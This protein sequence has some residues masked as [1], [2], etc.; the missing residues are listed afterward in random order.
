M[1]LERENVPPFQTTLRVHESAL[2]THIDRTLTSLE[3]LPGANVGDRAGQ[4]GQVSSN[5][6]L[7][8]CCSYARR[9]GRNHLE[10]FARAMDHDSSRHLVDTCLGSR[11]V[12]LVD[13]GSGASL[14]WILFSLTAKSFGNVKNVSVVNVDHAPNMHRIARKLESEMDVFLEQHAVEFDRRQASRPE[15]IN[16]FT[17]GELKQS[18]VIFLVLNHLLHQNH[19]TNLEVPDF[20]SQ[21]LSSCVQI[22]RNARDARLVGISL[23]PW[24]LHSGFGQAGLTRYVQGLNGN[25]SEP[26]KVAGDRAGKSVVTFSLDNF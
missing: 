22:A 7:V 6:R 21:A 23:E 14:T 26:F 25:V 9:N 15:G 24:G 17:T 12:I 4:M 16:S 13:L 19:S 1:E 5:I 2:E 10:S 18:P 11:Q 8:D 3:K 20:V